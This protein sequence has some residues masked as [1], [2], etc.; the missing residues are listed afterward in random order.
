MATD[1]T[2]YLL[3]GGESPTSRITYQRYLA[4]VLRG[5]S[6]LQ[7]KAVAAAMT[8]EIRQA[9]SPRSFTRVETSEGGFDAVVC[10]VSYHFHKHGQKYGTIARMTDEALRL[11]RERRAEARV[12]ATDGLLQFPDGSLFEVD[13][14]IVT[15]VS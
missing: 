11:F 9:W 4:D 5:K 10:N 14:R 6:L 3:Y 13:G 2:E 1:D 15:F 8:P 12:R 7:L